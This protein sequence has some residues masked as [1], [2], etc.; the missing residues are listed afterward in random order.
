MVKDM[1]F[2]RM[3]YSFLCPFARP[4][5]ISNSCRVSSLP[6]GV[7]TS[8]LQKSCKKQSEDPYTGA[9]A[10]EERSTVRGSGRAR[11]RRQVRL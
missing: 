3:F 8:L 7:V 2:S 10:P 1:S 6:A 4:T 11:R 5:T 9:S